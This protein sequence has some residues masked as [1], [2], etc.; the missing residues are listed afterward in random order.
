VSKL[1]THGLA[2]PTLPPIVRVI[3]NKKRSFCRHVESVDAKT[4]R[5]VTER[6]CEDRDD[7]GGGCEDA[8]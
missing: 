8:T 6:Q 4:V 2:S 3:E 7:L 5:D 1:N